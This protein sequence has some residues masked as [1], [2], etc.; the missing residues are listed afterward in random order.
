LETTADPSADP[1]AKP[2]SF[3]VNQ[4]NKKARFRAFAKSG[5]MGLEP[6]TFCMAS[7]SGCQSRLIATSGDAFLLRFCRSG[8]SVIVRGVTTSHHLL[9]SRRP[10]SD[11]L[12][13][14]DV[15]FDRHNAQNMFGPRTNQ[16]QSQGMATP[17]AATTP[18]C[19]PHA[20]THPAR[21]A[22]SGRSLGMGWL[23]PRPHQSFGG[24]AASRSW[25]CRFSLWAGAKGFAG[26]L[27]A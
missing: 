12:V 3:A 26:G 14:R 22:R 7:L 15:E 23:Q 6:T 9:T 19:T 13:D 10:R 11:L 17:P 8:P 20:R 18:P 1:R 5:M 16:N 4:D 27:T 25:N 21:R 2:A 24:F